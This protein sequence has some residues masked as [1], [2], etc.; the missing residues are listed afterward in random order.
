LKKEFDKLTEWFKIVGG[1]IVVSFSGDVNSS[2]ALATAVYANGREN[3]VAVTA[4]SPT[5]PEED[6]YWAKE[7]VKILNVK[8]ILIESD[9]LEDPNFISN[10]FNRCYYCKKSLS[11]S[12]LEIAKKLNAKAIVDVTNASDLDTHRPGYLAFREKE[13]LI[14]FSEKVRRKSIENVAWA[15]IYNLTLVPIAMG[16]LYSIG[17]TLRP[18]LAALAMIASNIS[19]VLN[20]LTLMKSG[21]R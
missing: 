21:I 20:S 2:V 9:E 1:F 18:E 19:V 11:K 5:Y 16:A 13:I 10:P 17:I 12:L 4:I 3:V 8:H 7:I 15:F 6:L 14:M